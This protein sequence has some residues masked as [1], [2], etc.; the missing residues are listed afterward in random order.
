MLW[1]TYL[2]GTPEVSLNEITRRT[3]STGFENITVQIFQY[4]VQSL[5][6]VADLG[7]LVRGGGRENENERIGFRW[8]S[9][10][11]QRPLDLKMVLNV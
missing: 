7:F 1:R 11:R 6:S 9:M 4:N 10:R 2:G 8:G 5:N 3:H